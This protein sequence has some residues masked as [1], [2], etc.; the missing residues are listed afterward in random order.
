MQVKNLVR[1]TIANCLTEI[2]VNN[3]LQQYQ[4]ILEIF[5]D[6][7]NVIEKIR[8]EYELYMNP[9]IINNTEAVRES[10]CKVTKDQLVE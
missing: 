4:D 10:F 1:Q 5:Y 9:I 2:V 8:A 7:R 6:E 3:E